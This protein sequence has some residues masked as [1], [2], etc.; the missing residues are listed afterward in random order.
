MAEKSLEVLVT[1][2]LPDEVLQRIRSLSPRIRISFHPVQK[3]DEIPVEVWSKA[4]VL[5]TDVLTPDPI[6]VPNLRWVQYHYAGIDYIQGSELAKRT[7]LKITNMSG[8]NVIQSA[9][10]LL[11]AMLML[12][13]RIPDLFGN[14]LKRDWPADRWER[15]TPFELNGATVGFVGYGS[16]ARET[17]R[18][19][20]PFKPTILAAKRDAMHPTDD[21]Y[22]I[23]G[24]G[25][26]EGN[27]FNRLYPIQA[28]H[29]MLK[30]SDFVIVTLPLTP[31]TRG[32][33]GENEFKV[34]KPGSFL[35]NTSRGGI[36]DE[37]AL[38]AALQEKKIGGAIFDVF[39]QEPL[40]PD[41]PMWKQPNLFLT[42]HVSGFSPIYKL[43][44]GELFIENLQRYLHGDALLNMYNINRN[45]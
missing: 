2:A 33:F 17:A 12:G 31:E 4:E 29:S 8:A 15:F 32:I 20:Q 3:V 6:L 1:V 27:L 18:L 5:Y 30:E 44:A 36:V 19:L 39:A 43:R 26:P 25:D 34:M 10:Y 40:P 37:S 45:Y 16:I 23:E 22:I 14:Q 11:M 41:S 42:P 21:G 38:I 35:I 13:H 7:D 24:R 28:L 9:E